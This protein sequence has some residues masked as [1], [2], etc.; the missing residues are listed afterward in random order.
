MNNETVEDLIK[1]LGEPDSQFA[2]KSI[3]YY[4]GR[5]SEELVK[6]LSD[7]SN[8]RKSWRE[9]GLQPR[10][11]NLTKAIVDKSGL[12]FNGPQPI[13][14]VWTNG[15]V[16]QQASQNLKDLMDSVEWI[17]FFTNFDNQVRMLKTSLVLVQWDPVSNKPIFDALH[18]GNAAVALDCNTRQVTDLLVLTGDED[19]DEYRHFDVNMIT[20]L[21]YDKESKELVITAQ[22]PNP[23]GIVP[24]AAFHDTSTPRYGMWNVPPTDLVGLNEMYNLHLMD[25]EY[26]AAWSKVKTLFTN[27]DISSNSN[28]T[29]TWVDP[30]TGIPRQI[31]QSPSVVGG[32]GKVVQ[33]DAPPGATPYVEYKGPDVNLTPVE[34][35]FS[36]WVKDFAGDWSVRLQSAGDASATSGFQLVV[37]EMP[38]LELRKQRQKMFISGFSRLYKVLTFVTAGVPGAALP[39]DGVLYVTFHAPALPVDDKAQ[40]EVWSRRILEGRASRVDYFMSTQGMSREEA[41]AKVAEIDALNTINPSVPTRNTTVRVA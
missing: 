17:E 36:Q 33:V 3:N 34:E 15:A 18:K 1:C 19:E 26:S 9:K 37:E 27:A 6:A 41:I 35:M 11:R 14:E 31:P 12:L 32:P 2:R 21:E 7:P 8:F 28:L 22:F 4:D 23:Y 25:S 16:N 40:E 30:Q 10:T 13:L 38:N 20:D 29:Q 5:Q 24:V 39:I